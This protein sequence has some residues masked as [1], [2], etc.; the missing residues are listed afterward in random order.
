MKHELQRR[1]F[2]KGLA[3]VA[4]AA[5]VAPSIARASSP[6]PAAAAPEPSRFWRIEYSNDGIGW[7]GL[8]DNFIEYDFGR[9]VVIEEV[10]L[11][12]SDKK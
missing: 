6:P 3:L 12:S 10:R 9:P 5:A 8:G 7:E 2:L 11:V 4:P 1:A